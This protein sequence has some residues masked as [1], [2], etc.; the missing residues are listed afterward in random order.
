MTTRPKSRTPRP[1]ADQPIEPPRGGL[2]AP[3]PCGSGKR[4]KQCHGRVRAGAEFVARPF[5]GLPHE[6][7]WVA[8][9]EIVPAATMR[10]RTVDGDDVTFA[11]VLP[12]AWPALRRAD[13]SVFV[14]VQ[15]ADASADASRDLAAAMDAALAADGPGPVT[16][17]DARRS[18]AR[19]QDRLDLDTPPVLEV[20][21]GFD[22]W[23]DGVLDTDPGEAEDPSDPLSALAPQVRASLERANAA[24]VPTEK[25]TSAESAYWCRIG[26]NVHLRWVIATPEDRFLDALARLHVT[27]VDGDT[28]GS[29]LGPGTRFAGFFRA[30]GLVVPVWDLPGDMSAEGTEEPL[31]SFAER[32]QDALA[33]SDP[34]DAE[35]RRARAGLTS[36]QVTLR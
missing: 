17:V 26:D 14:G 7:D 12:V 16:H 10:A 18:T 35:Q 3:C 31:A 2:R 30:Y 25:L 36:R 33:V 5:E 1:A 9:R 28:A 20:H 29:T 21:E 15:A 32:F 23:V 11:T 8:F 27:T 4:Y 6:T 13:G 34:L 24:V 22:F 19:L